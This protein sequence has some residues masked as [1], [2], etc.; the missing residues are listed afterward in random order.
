M[1]Y[2]YDDYRRILRFYRGFNSDTFKAASAY[3]LFLKWRK[4]NNIDLIRDDIISGRTPYPSKFP[5]GEKILNICPQIVLTTKHRDKYGRPIALERYDF[6]MKEFLEKVPLEE[7]YLFLLYVCE[8]RSLIVEQLSDEYER[9]Y[10]DKHPDPKSRK[11]PY[12]VLLG[13]CSIRDLRGQLQI[14]YP[15]LFLVNMPVPI[16]RGHD[17]SLRL[18]WENYC[19]CCIKACHT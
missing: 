2:I 17:E 1:T 15:Y 16:C 18:S 4:E 5:N 19:F 9:E 3:A 10:L 14:L 8:Y 7:F 13:V 12:G 11:S 6:S